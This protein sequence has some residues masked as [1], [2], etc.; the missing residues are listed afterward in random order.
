MFQSAERDD[1]DGIVDSWIDELLGDDLANAFEAEYEGGRHD[2]T[3]ILTQIRAGIVRTLGRVSR[4]N[5]PR[6]RR[7]GPAP[8]PAIVHGEVTTRANEARGAGQLLQH[9]VQ[10]WMRRGRASA[11][12]QGNRGIATVNPDGSIT[13]TV[14]GP[15]MRT[16]IYRQL[17][18]PAGSVSPRAAVGTDDGAAQIRED[19]TRRVLARIPT[20][21]QDGQVGPAQVFRKHRSHESGPDLELLAFL[22][23][24]HAYSY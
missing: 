14:Y 20:V 4:A 6:M 12:P 5:I 2:F 7:G 21:G 3:R 18:A 1:A 22:P 19:T 23:S 13:W 17:I 16:I 15:D 11:P 8:V 9:S 10:G 24:P